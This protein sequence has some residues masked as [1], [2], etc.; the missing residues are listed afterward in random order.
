M[1]GC[2]ECAGSLRVVSQST[3]LVE[4]REVVLIA[5]VG[6]EVDARAEK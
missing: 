3:G 6:G 1:E 4:E 5:K 2:A